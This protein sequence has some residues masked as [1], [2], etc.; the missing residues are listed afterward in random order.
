MPE[1]SGSAR[2][3]ASGMSPAAL[4]WKATSTLYQRGACGSLLGSKC[5]CAVS[6]ALGSGKPAF[7]TVASPAMPGSGQLLW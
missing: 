6:K 4:A 7:A 2:S 1:A 5:L 3:H